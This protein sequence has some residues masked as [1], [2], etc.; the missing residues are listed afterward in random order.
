MADQVHRLLEAMVPELEDYK[1]RNLFTPAELQSIV[2]QRTQFEY[3]LQRRLPLLA[4]YLLYIQYELN[5]NALRRKRRRRLLSSPSSLTPVKS[6]L[7]DH[8]ILSRVCFLFER[9]LRRFHL[10]LPLW[11]QYV[12]FLRSSASHRLLARVFPRM[13]SLHPHSIPL[14]LLEA[15][16]HMSEGNTLAMRATLQRA[17]RLNPDAPQLWLRFFA[18]EVEYIAKVMERKRVLGLNIPDPLRGDLDTRFKTAPSPSSPSPSTPTLTPLDDVVMHARLPA[19]IFRNAIAQQQP[20][21]RQYLL[22]RR[23][24]KRGEAPPAPIPPAKAGLTFRLGFLALIPAAGNGCYRADGWQGEARELVESFK[25][26]NAGLYLRP[27]EWDELIAQ[28]Y[29]SIA[30]DFPSDPQAWLVRA[31]RAVELSGVGGACDVFEQGLGEVKGLCREYLRYLL[32]ALEAEG[33]PAEGRQR[34]MTGLETALESAQADAAADADTALLASQALTR[35][36]R[37]SEAQQILVT[38]GASSRRADVWLRRIQLAG[39]VERAGL[40]A[41]AISSVEEDERHLVYAEQLQS[42]VATS[43]PA[44]ASSVLE[45]F[46]HALGHCRHES[47]VELYADYLALLLSAGALILTRLRQVIDA[48]PPVPSVAY[49]HAIRLHAAYQVKADREGTQWLRRQWERVVMDE[50]RVGDVTTWREWVRMEREAGELDFAN[51]LIWRAGKHVSPT[52]LNEL[53]ST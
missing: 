1:R 2:Q 30:A 8:A 22:P 39:E 34:L 14:W 48:L 3:R 28:I 27:V 25:A 23:K 45:R 26:N 24:R 32:T 12:H 9:A 52:D 37:A 29:A 33:V 13:H 21:D 41:E 16:Y 51:Q 4:D 31:K 15:S 17:L 35:L 38:A 10:S 53:T 44:V 5:L 6:S 40:Y 18:W 11:H 49:L 42:L 43:S 20:K 36:S 7:S 46:H 50:G 47:L 19:A